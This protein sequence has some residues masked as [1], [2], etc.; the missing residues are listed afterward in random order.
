MLNLKKK[1]LD[2]ENQ[3]VD[4]D[5]YNA[6]LFKP[7]VK[8]SET[9]VEKM[10]EKND[11]INEII[12]NTLPYYENQEQEQLSLPLDK[13]EKTV[14]NF[15]KP[16]EPIQK[17]FLDDLSQNKKVFLYKKKNGEGVYS[18]VKI[19]GVNNLIKATN[20]ELRDEYNSKDLKKLSNKLIGYYANNQNNKQVLL[21][22]SAIGKYQKLIKDILAS[23][24][25]AE[26]KEDKDNVEDIE[27]ELRK[28]KKGEGIKKRNGYKI[29]N[30]KYNQ[31]LLNMPKLLNEMII[32]AKLSNDD[33]VLYTNKCDRSTINLLTKRYN[34][35][36]KY[37][38]LAK[39]IFNDLN[40]LSGMVKKRNMK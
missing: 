40:E 24:E 14:Y 19:I 6:E 34:P 22:R 16:L 17:A 5:F 36:M 3:K 39:Q 8:S 13:D 7:I 20:D 31:L 30:S 32:E 27:I 25:Y 12:T 35:K 10:E 2:F 4:R 1:N 9:L 28:S 18:N 11:K 26:K 38:Q 23:R 37:T 21:Y 33:D 29:V 15:N